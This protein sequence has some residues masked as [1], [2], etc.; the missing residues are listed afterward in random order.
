[1][2]ALAAEIAREAE[3]GT[4]LLDTARC[5]PKKDLRWLAHLAPSAQHYLLREAQ[6]LVAGDQL[7]DYRAYPK[8]MEFH[9]AGRHFYHRLIR[10]GNQNGKTYPV[11][12][13]FA[14]HVTGEYPPRWPGHVFPF[15]IRA[16]ATSETAKS[17]RE[18]VQR[19]LF[20]DPGAFGTG[21]IPAR[22]ITGKMAMAPGA[23]DLI[24]YALVRHVTGA[25]S[26]VS[27]RYYKQDRDSWQGPPVNLMWFDEE[28]PPDMY[29]EGQSR[30]NGVDGRSMMSMSLLK[31]RS[32]VANKYIDPEHRPADFHDTKMTI[33]DAQHI[34]RERIPGIIAKYPEHERAARIWGEP[35]Q[36]EGLIYPVPEDQ[37]VIDPFEIPD[38]WAQLGGFDF[39]SASAISHPTATARIAWDRDNDVLYVTAE[40]KR[41]GLTIPEHCITLRA[42][43]R[44]LVWQWPRDGYT[45]EAGTGH[46]V[47]DQYRRE[48]LKMH[49]EHSHYAETLAGT[50]SNRHKVST[51]RGVDEILARMRTSR[52]KVF[53]TCTQ[54]LEEVRQ[55]HRKDG[56]I[57]RK[58]NDLM[59]ATRVGVM[60]R[61]HAATVDTRKKRRR[62]R[63]PSWR[64]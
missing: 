7:Q 21:W 44:D 51:E 42:W 48:G 54:W 29:G 36:G 34:A 11:G 30:L 12:A 57:V 19:S 40:Y 1:M 37:F 32:E 17:T 45:H 5:L 26:I 31:G 9:A 59:D 4:L 63:P 3:D 13:E 28:P 6:T 14:M 60:G 20:G 25:T 56:L 43:G 55:Y 49:F 15:A 53:N 35:M 33:Y 16:W 23:G 62:R 18:N 58:F 61:R 22:C 8:Q 10:A 52:F 47:A 24:D 39:G 50:G 27:F 64:G 38:W 41:T 2:R 46:Q